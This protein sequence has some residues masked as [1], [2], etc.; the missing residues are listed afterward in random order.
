VPHI[1]AGAAVIDD[2]YNANP[3][4]VEAAIDV[5]AAA[6]AA[7]A[8]AGRHGRSRANG[9]LFHDEIG[10]YAR[11]AGVERLFAVGALTAASV[12]AFG[13]GAQHFSSV[14]AL[15]RMWRR[16]GGGHDRARQGLA[17]HADGARRAALTARGARGSALMLLWLT[18]LLAKDIRAFNVFGYLT[19]RAVLACMTR[20]VISFIVGPK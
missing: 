3:D 4:S 16:S 10:A 15:A 1:A 9:P 17:L 6:R 11:A 2:T 18:E 19:L 8:R 12:A 13:A 14:E 7:V 20:S 5:L